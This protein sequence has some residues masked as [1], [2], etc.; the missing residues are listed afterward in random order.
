SDLVLQQQLQNGT[1][2]QQFLVQNPSFF[3]PNTTVSS[4]QF[5]QSATAPQTIYQVNGNLR[6]PY[7][8]QTGVTIERQLTKSANLSVTYLNSRGNHQVFT[9]FINANPIPPGATVAPAPSQILYQFQSE[10]VFKQ[11]QSI[12][13]S[14]I[15]MG[16]R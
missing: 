6:T 7:T 10:G 5:S 12:V 15:R 4:S 2:Q 13:N 11:N 1:I 16:T 14:S 9:N 8:M 3:D